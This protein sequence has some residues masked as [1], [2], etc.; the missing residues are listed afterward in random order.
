MSGWLDDKDWY[1]LLRRIQEGRCTP[2]LGAGVCAGTMPLAGDIARE[3]SAKY[4]YPL[5]DCDDLVRVSQF[6]AVDRDP[7]FP[8][9]E[10]CR[11]FREMPPP[12]FSAADEPHSFLAG[13]P[14]PI[15]IT[16]NYDG[17]MLE[18][19]RRRAKDARRG[20]CP[21]N[22]YMRDEPS[23]FATGQEYDPTPANPLV[24]HLHGHID[25]PESIVLTEDDYLDF[26]MNL[27]QDPDLLPHRIR[28]AFTG[29]SLLFLGYRIADWSF[30]VIFRSLVTY[31]ERSIAKSHVSVQLVPYE[32]HLRP[33][34]VPRVQEYLNRYFGKQDIRIYWGTAR[35]FA[36]ELRQRWE[37]FQ[38]A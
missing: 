20:F 24:F 12:D 35:E 4:T 18:A 14:L 25:Y 5:Q 22:R 13:L 34:D 30:R 32:N 6:L 26:V 21:W 19:L 8:K 3:W 10:M 37:D 36:D 29:T 1:S 2:F 27:S 17:T 38:N 28:R 15:Y 7:A 16:T 31:L 11:R 23:I 33:G 9:E